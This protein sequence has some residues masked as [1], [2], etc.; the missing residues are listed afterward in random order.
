MMLSPRDG[1]FF[2]AFKAA[3]LLTDELDEGLCDLA[4]AFIFPL[5]HPGRI[6]DTQTTISDWQLQYFSLIICDIP[7]KEAR[8]ES[9]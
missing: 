5:R 3:I 2:K 6:D 7:S 8:D 1:S 9:F 4:R